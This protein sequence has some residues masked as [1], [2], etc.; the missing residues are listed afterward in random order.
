MKKIFSPCTLVIDGYRY[1][2]E[3]AEFDVPAFIS[4]D[5]HVTAGE[6]QLTEGIDFFVDRRAGTISWSS[7]QGSIEVIATGMLKSEGT[8][9]RLATRRRQAQWKA[10][11]RGFR[12]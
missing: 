6:R 3:P 12:P 2:F 1:R 11:Q 9:R 4:G 10:E 8:R 5:V 7:V